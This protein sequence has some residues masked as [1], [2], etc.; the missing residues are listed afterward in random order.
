M[1]AATTHD[2][3]VGCEVQAQHLTEREGNERKSF[4]IREHES[5]SER[6]VVSD[7]DS[8]IQRP[9]QD[10][11]LD[12]EFARLHVSESKEGLITHFFHWKSRGSSL[13]LSFDPST[14]AITSSVS[15]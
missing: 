7:L 8:R 13:T 12:S 5:Q 11:T 6:V 15:R 9:T 2:K 14:H 3:S 1:S 4:A 10:Q